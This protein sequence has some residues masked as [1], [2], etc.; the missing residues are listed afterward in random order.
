MSVGTG[1]SSRQEGLALAARPRRSSAPAAVEPRRHAATVA[2][3]GRCGSG[4]LLSS[5]AGRC[6]APA[7]A[8][9]SF[10]ARR[11]TSATPTET[12][13][14]TTVSSMRPAIEAQ[15]EAGVRRSWDDA[16][17]N[18]DA[19]A[20]LS[21]LLLLGLAT[22]G[23]MTYALRRVRA[24][25]LQSRREAMTEERRG[26][27]LAGWATACGS[28]RPTVPSAPL[29]SLLLL[30]LH[31]NGEST[32]EGR[33]KVDLPRGTYGLERGRR[34]RL[35]PGAR[36][37]LRRSL[38]CFRQGAA[39]MPIYLPLEETSKRLELFGRLSARSGYREVGGGL[40]I[41]AA[42]AA[43]DPRAARRAL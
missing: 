8:R 28:C 1:R 42:K 41:E 27:R 29:S 7:A 16:D 34:P 12:G 22:I 32:D 6:G 5:P 39:G 9:S 37:R 30:G 14:A 25:R 40:P 24:R 36:G 23:G 31:G 33:S 4:S 17:A 11:S 38:P 10:P 13:R 3:T 26:R 2:R 43:R 18:T 21:S 35:P 15:R 20:P 19:P